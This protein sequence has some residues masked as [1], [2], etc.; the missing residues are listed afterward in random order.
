MDKKEFFL[1]F[2]VII[3]FLTQSVLSFDSEIKIKST[4]GNAITL[5]ILNQYT[6]RIVDPENG[7]FNLVTDSNGDGI[8]NYKTSLALFKISIIYDAGSGEKV[9]KFFDNIPSDKKVY[10]DLTQGNPASVITDFNKIEE[11]NDTVN[12]EIINTTQENTTI[13]NK[14]ENSTEASNKTITANAIKIGNPLKGNWIYYLGIIIVAGVIALLIFKRNQIVPHFNYHN[15]EYNLKK[16]EDEISDAEKKIQ[17][18]I[19]R[20]QR[21]KNMENKINKDKKDL[22]RLR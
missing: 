15:D 7:V 18:I 10:I 22:R 21:L 11:K 3:V 9:I 5:N 16:A 13:D 19:I 17:D 6:G 14:E 12:E 8:V 1:V 4:S 20:N 2:L